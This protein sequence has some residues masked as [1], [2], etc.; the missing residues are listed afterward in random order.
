MQLGF[1]M[2]LYIQQEA[3]EAAHAALRREALVQASA[4]KLYEVPYLALC[5][6]YLHLS[7][8]LSVPTVAVVMETVENL[9]LLSDEYEQ[10]PKEGVMRMLDEEAAGKVAS[11][12]NHLGLKVDTMQGAVSL[13][14]SRLN[15]ARRQ[16][17]RG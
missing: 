4:P 3:Q 2:Q 8:F 14:P 17:T 13:S 11:A 10:Y 15:S 16:H 5:S 7:M 12:R 9:N 6:C 1:L